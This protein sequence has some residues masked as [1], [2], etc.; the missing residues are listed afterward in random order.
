[1]I[2]VGTSV[3]IAVA[4][5]EPEAE[6]FTPFIGK[7]RVV[8]HSQEVGESGEEPVAWGLDKLFA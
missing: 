4:A 3:I 6:V 2:A 1:M 7:E 5:D 8:R